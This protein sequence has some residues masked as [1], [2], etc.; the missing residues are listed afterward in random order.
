MELTA[1]R[2]V[3]E[4]VTNVVRHA[5]ASR[6]AVTVRADTAAQVLLVTVEDDGRGA[7]TGGYWPRAGAC[8]DARAGAFASV[9]R[10]RPA[11]LPSGGFLVSAVLPIECARVIRVVLADDQALI[12][13]GFKAILERSDD[14]EVVGE[15]ADGREAVELARRTRP[16]VIVMDVRMPRLDG[17]APPASVIADSSLPNTHVLVVTT[18]EL[19]ETVFEAL[20]AGASG[21]LLKDL[22]PD[23]LRRAVRDRRIRRVAARSERHAA[24]HRALRGYCRGVT[25]RWRRNCHA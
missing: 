9:E 2:I 3:Q 13:E 4:A 8:R 5:S 6:V 23:D 14:I 19:D 25:Q 21:F 12:R 20:R 1:Y 16:D 11:R 17:I 18:Y 10:S 22:E 24:A 15:A 7:P